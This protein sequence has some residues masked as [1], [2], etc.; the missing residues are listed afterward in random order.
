MEIKEIVMGVDYVDL[1]KFITGGNHG[2]TTKNESD[3]FN[4]D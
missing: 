3:D 1:R 4:N 2:T